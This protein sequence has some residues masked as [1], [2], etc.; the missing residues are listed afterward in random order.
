MLGVDRMTSQ[1]V[2]FL[3]VDKGKKCSYFWYHKIRQ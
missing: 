3:E 2:D 1:K